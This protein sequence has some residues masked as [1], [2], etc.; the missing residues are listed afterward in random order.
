MVKDSDI[1]VNLIGILFEKNKANSFENIHTNFPDLLSRLCNKH[2]T[3][4]IHFSALG[5][6]KALDSNYAISK[7]NGE[8]KIMQNHN[9]S[10][11]LKP[12]IVFSVSD[13]FTT[14]FLGILSN[15]PIIP[16]YYNGQTKFTPIHAS[17]VADIIYH[18]ISKGITE[19]SIEVIG[20]EV[21]SFK[22]MIEVLLKCINKK[23]ILLPLPNSIA[24]ISTYFL[25]KLPNPP[26]TLDQFRL[27]KYHNVQSQNGIT[28]FSI[29]C[30]SKIKF[31]E[32]V[33]KYAYN[34]RDGGQY[35]INQNFNK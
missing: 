2:N 8:K 22:E 7:I 12:S 26:I 34:W 1:C 10:V 15:L 33:L 17:E 4:L 30:P 16:I 5:L 32:G 28:N 3:H 11:I 31:E 6:E 25:Q 20:P 21:L 19:K 18:I 13:S 14:K 35:S 24:K 29:G 9:K 23:R 27:L